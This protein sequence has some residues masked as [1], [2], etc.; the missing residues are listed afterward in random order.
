[1]EL[2][3]NSI[4][5]VGVIES[6]TVS[7]DDKIISGNARH[8]KI[9]EVLGVDTEPI[10]IETDGTQPIILKRTDIQSGTKQFTEAALLANTTAKQN[11]NL[12]FDLIQEIAIDEFDIDIVELGVE[13]ID[14]EEPKE[15]TA[16][17]KNEPPII[18]IT[19][20]S[21]KQMEQF[22]IEI[23]RLIAKEEFLNVMYSVSQGEI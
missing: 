19:F 17:Y 21:T 8:E 10:V 23:K 6:I 14:L 9:S 12:D 7:N 18:K 22:E 13:I 11:I 15:L 2:L 16:P 3:G 4:A 5:K 1:M 20:S